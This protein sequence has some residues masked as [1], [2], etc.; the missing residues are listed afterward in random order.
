MIAIGLDPSMAAFGYSVIAG[1][2]VWAAGVWTTAP[3][4]RAG[5]KDDQGERFGFLAKSLAELARATLAHAEGTAFVDQ[6]LVLFVEA[7]TLQAQKSRW[8]AS[9]LGRA[10]GIVDGVAAARGLE[11]FEVDADQRKRVVPFATRADKVSKAQ[12]RTAVLELYPAALTYLP[13]TVLGHNASDAVAL[14]H[15]GSELWRFQR[16]LKSARSGP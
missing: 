16:Q 5:A 10:R 12:I 11:V 3:N 9:M 13:D 8:N 2:A 7:T 4:K 15:V 14:A 1:H 6:G